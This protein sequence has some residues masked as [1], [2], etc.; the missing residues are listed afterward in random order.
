MA[1]ALVALVALF[2]VLWVA[3]LGLANASIVDTWWGPAFLVATAMY[4]EASPPRTPRAW[5]VAA[6]VILWAVRL[7]WHIGRRNTGHGEDPRYRQMRER[8]GARWW[9]RSYVQVFLLQAT[10]A[11][12]VSW[13]LYFAV[14]SGS[15][16]PT[17]LDLLGL[18]LFAIGWSLE[19]VADAQLIGFK[20]EASN[21]GRVME[22]GLWRYSRHPNYFGEALLWWGI[23]L[24][25]V[26]ALGG[27]LGLIGPALLTFLLLRV[28]GVAL[29]E[30]GL[31]ASK[32]DYPQ[33]VA[34]TSAFIPWPPKPVDS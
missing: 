22:R 14:R 33:Y 2:S 6:V 31:L 23:G 4:L 7:A 28:S 20:R 5:V 17:A 30:R 11:W 25:G 13:P 21:R 10:I 12:I 19:T 18:A 3:S 16:F 8:H 1:D 9:W 32:P 26:S 29:L 34:R 27:W 15:P 24:L